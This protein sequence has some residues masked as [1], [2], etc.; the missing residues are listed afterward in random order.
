[1][2]EALRQAPTPTEYKAQED[3]P[4]NGTTARLWQSSVSSQETVWDD[5]KALEGVSKNVFQRRI[6]VN[7]MD[8]FELKKNANPGWKYSY[9]SIGSDDVLEIVNNSF[10][11]K[12]EA[13]P[14]VPFCEMLTGG[15][16][17]IQEYKD[18]IYGDTKFDHALNFWG[19]AKYAM[20]GEKDQAK[21]SF[22]LRRR[23]DSLT[24]PEGMGRIQGDQTNLHWMSHVRSGAT[25]DVLRVFHRE[26]DKTVNISL[27]SFLA[28]GDQNDP[29]TLSE[30]MPGGKPLF[31]TNDLEIEYSQT[32]WK[33]EKLSLR[34]CSSMRFYNFYKTVP[35]M[36]KYNQVVGFRT[37]TQSATNAKGLKTDRMTYSLCLQLHQSGGTQPSKTGFKCK[38]A[39][40]SV[41]DTTDGLTTPDFIKP[42]QNAN[43][44]D[45]GL[46]VIRR[47]GS[48][49]SGSK[50][51]E[52]VVEVRAYWLGLMAEHGLDQAQDL[53]FFQDSW[54]THQLKIKAPASFTPPLSDPAGW[55]VLVDDVRNCGRPELVFLVGGGISEYSIQIFG[56]D[57]D[58]SL[59]ERKIASV[60]AV[61]KVLPTSSWWNLDFSKHRFAALCP[62]ETTPWT[63]DIIQ[64]SQLFHYGKTNA[65]KVGTPD[66]YIYFRTVRDP[67]PSPFAFLAM[68]QNQRH[69]PSLF[70]TARQTRSALQH[71]HRRPILT[72]FPSPV[73][74]RRSSAAEGRYPTRMERASRTR[75]IPLAIRR[76]RPPTHRD[77]PADPKKDDDPNK[78]PRDRL[79]PRNRRP[80][81]GLRRRHG[82]QR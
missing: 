12:K 48:S 9:S 42:Y 7:D 78:Q 80:A 81:Q 11:G 25:T 41:W 35:G 26:S 1:M 13:F 55:Q 16:L 47:L 51:K 57:D 3:G 32:F 62:S 79:R 33:N 50:D 71:L 53:S 4:W 37:Y 64:V 14:A 74:Q 44:T 82:P 40:K 20:P 29:A 28:S 61:P 38:V 43:G 10:I 68:R 70:F 21:P 24:Y 30:V 66:K 46:L 60:P 19:P 2:Y 63:H 23:W 31:P 34:D 22:M 45:H 59:T 15:F 58:G 27:Y 49:G 76:N 56:F 6:D 36:D 52:M 54:T 69:V 5:A 8:N 67:H 18:R 77:D 75:R 65:L 39:P 73:D 72:F 17:Q